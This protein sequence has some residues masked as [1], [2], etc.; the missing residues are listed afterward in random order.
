MMLM[1]CFQEKQGESIVMK[2]LDSEEDEV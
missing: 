1:A 2:R